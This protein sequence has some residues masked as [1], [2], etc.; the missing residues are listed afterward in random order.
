MAVFVLA[1]VDETLIATLPPEAGALVSGRTKKFVTG[2]FAKP[3]ATVTDWV[4][5]IGEPATTVRLRWLVELSEETT[6]RANDGAA[7]NRPPLVGENTARAGAA[8]SEIWKLTAFSAESRPSSSVACTRN[9]KSPPGAADGG[10]VKAS[11]RV[12]PLEK[13]VKRLIPPMPTTFRLVT[14]ESSVAPTDRVKIW[15]L[16]TGPPAGLIRVSVATGGWLVTVLTTSSANGPSLLKRSVAM[17][18]M[19]VPPPEGSWTAMRNGEFVVVPM[20][21]KSWVNRTATSASGDASSASTCTIV[22]AMGETALTMRRIP[23]TGPMVSSVLNWTMS[24]WFGS[25]LPARS[26]MPLTV[27]V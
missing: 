27:S 6:V 23:R 17:A 19:V 15:P 11:V 16:P 22:P 9:S 18:R 4:T 2:A 21:T 1:S 24:G 26:R 14:R 8:R 5:L 25:A 3:A 20:V 7:G 10:T 13:L 12:S